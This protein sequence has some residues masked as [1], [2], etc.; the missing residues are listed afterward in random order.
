MLLLTSQLTSLA[1]QGTSIPLLS[2]KYRLDPAHRHCCCCFPDG[3]SC[4][5]LQCRHRLW[6][7]C[8]DGLRQWLER[9]AEQWFLSESAAVTLLGLLCLIVCMAVLRLKGTI[10]R[11]KF[12]PEWYSWEL[13]LSFH[14]DRTSSRVPWKST[15]LLKYDLLLCRTRSAFHTSLDECDLYEEFEKFAV[16]TGEILAWQSMLVCCV[17]QYRL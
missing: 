6:V 1:S 10:K 11:V 14:P 4:K 13:S 3:E 7:G 8:G 15:E 12:S 9:L 5:I 2:S 17:L 16:E